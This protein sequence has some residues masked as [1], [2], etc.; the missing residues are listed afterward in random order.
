MGAAGRAGSAVAGPRGPDGSIASDPDGGV[1]G[2]GSGGSGTGGTGGVSGTDSAVARDS[3]VPP[4]DGSTADAGTD[5][6]STDAGSDTGTHVP[7]PACT[8]DS[9]LRDGHATWYEL[10]TPL[11]NC[12]YETP[13]LPRYYAAMNEDDYGSAAA[14]GRCVRVIHAEN[15]RTIDVLIVDQCPFLGNEQWCYAGSH[16]LDL[17][18]AA[19]ALLDD[20]VRGHF[21][22]RWRYI[23]CNPAGN[24][25]YH[26]HADASQYWMAVQIRDHR[27][28]IASVE[29]ESSGQYRWLNRE[30]WNY[31]TGSDAGGG[32]YSFR[33]TDIHGQVLVDHNIP[34]SPGQDVEGSG[35]FEPCA[36][37]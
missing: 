19:F 22:V 28:A 13:T 29:V 12:S 23:A 17:D 6:G 9:A 11:V 8:E 20:P 7:P 34:L 26:F 21:P 37:Y 18:P 27:Y 4:G 36:A 24:I 35:Q 31:W 32:P 3:A 33:V 16:H 25:R 1:P 30:S 2:A 14:C 15:G 10:T 5:S